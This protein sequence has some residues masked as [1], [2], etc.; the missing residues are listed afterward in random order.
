ML[1]TSG[2]FYTRT[3][4]PLQ[5]CPPQIFK[6]LLLCSRDC[7]F[8]HQSANPTPAHGS[9]THVVGILNPQDELPTSPPSQQEVEESGAQRAKMQEASWGRCKSC[10]CRAIREVC[11]R[12]TAGGQSSRQHTASPEEATEEA[13]GRGVGRSCQHVWNCEVIASA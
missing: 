10:P 8:L 9:F 12:G 6:Y 7:P 5:P 11:L 2:P 1:R 3:F 13:D 4:I